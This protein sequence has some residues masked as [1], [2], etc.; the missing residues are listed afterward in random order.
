M[1]AHFWMVNFLKLTYGELNFMINRFFCGPGIEAVID[2]L[3]HSQELSI[4]WNA[5]NSETQRFALVKVLHAKFCRDYINS[6]QR[7]RE[8]I[9]CKETKD[10]NDG[11]FHMILTGLRALFTPPGAILEIEKGDTIDLISRLVKIR[12]N[13]GGALDWAIIKKPLFRGALVLG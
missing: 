8:G 13:R 12:Y 5:D 4:F 6:C 11:I 1:L 2:A 9:V 10:E 3:N 7:G